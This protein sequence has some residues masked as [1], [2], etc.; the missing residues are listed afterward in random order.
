MDNLKEVD[1]VVQLNEAA[2]SQYTPGM[3]LFSLLVFKKN[4]RVLEQS[5]LIEYLQRNAQNQITI[6]SD[7]KPYQLDRWLSI[8]QRQTFFSQLESEHSLRENT[9]CLQAADPD[10]A[11]PVTSIV[12]VYESAIRD[13]TIDVPGK[14][15]AF[16]TDGLAEYHFELIETQARQNI[17]IINANRV[18]YNHFRPSERW[19]WLQ[20]KNAE[21]SAKAANAHIKRTAKRL[22]KWAGR[23]GTVLQ[24]VDYGYDAWE[25]WEDKSKIDLVLDATRIPIDWIYSETETALISAGII[26]AAGAI[27]VTLTPAG[28]ITLTFGGNYLL[29]KVK[30]FAW[31]AN[32]RQISE[33]FSSHES[34]DVA[35]KIHHSV[36]QVYGGELL[37]VFDI[38]RLRQ[39]DSFYHHTFLPAVCEADSNILNLDVDSAHA[40]MSDLNNSK[41]QEHVLETF[42]LPLQ[43][44]VTTE[45]ENS[46]SANIVLNK[47]YLISFQSGK[48][49]LVPT[50]RPTSI[51]F[52]LNLFDKPATAGSNDV[53]CFYQTDSGMHYGEPTHQA[54]VRVKASLL[55][56]TG[57]GVALAP[58]VGVSIAFDLTPGLLLT[59]G[60]VGAGVG[61]L[62]LGTAFAIK[63]IRE[64][65]EWKNLSP[66]QKTE[67]ILQKQVEHL[68]A[69]NLHIY[70]SYFNPAN[71]GCS[72]AEL[73][74]EAYFGMKRALRNCIAS[75]PDN[76]S[77]VARCRAMEYA[78][79]SGNTLAQAEWE[80][81]QF[82][83]TKQHYDANFIALTQSFEDFRRGN[84]LLECNK[85]L[86]ALTYYYPNEAFAYYAKS[87][88]QEKGNPELAIINMK[89]AISVARSARNKSQQFIDELE[90]ACLQQLVRL[91]IDPVFAASRDHYIEEIK[92]AAF[93]YVNNNSSQQK[94]LGQLFYL[95]RTVEGLKN[96]KQFSAQALQKID[97]YLA[98]HKSDFEANLWSGWLHLDE[99]NIEI[100]KQRVKAVCGREKKSDLSDL[101][102]RAHYLGVQV[103]KAEEDMS[104]VIGHYAEI[105]A[106]LDRNEFPELQLPIAQMHHE[107][108]LAYFSRAE[109]LVNKNQGNINDQSRECY[110][111][112]KEHLSKVGNVDKDLT[113]CMINDLVDVVL[114]ESQINNVEKIRL[115]VAFDKFC[116]FYKEQR[117]EKLDTNILQIGVKTA[118]FIAKVE[119]G[120]KGLN[121]LKRLD[122]FAIEDALLL[123]NINLS[124]ALILNNIFQGLNKQYLQTKDLTLLEQARFYAAECINI[125]EKIQASDW[126]S[127]K[128]LQGYAYWVLGEKSQA[129]TCFST[130]VDS[131]NATAENI[132]PVVHDE[133]WKQKLKQAHTALSDIALAE[134]EPDLAT[135]VREREAALEFDP[136]A[137]EIKKTLGD[138][139]AQ[140]K[141]YEQAHARYQEYLDEDP[142]NVE[143]TMHKVQIYCHQNNL[144][145]ARELLEKTH[146]AR[147]SQQEILEKVPEDELAMNETL[148]KAKNGIDKFERNIVAHDL[149]LLT[150]YIGKL[151]LTHHYGNQWDAKKWHYFIGAY[152]LLATLG[153]PRYM[154]L[155]YEALNDAIGIS[156]SQ[157]LAMKSLAKT[158]WSALSL[159]TRSANIVFSTLHRTG[160][161][162]RNGQFK[163]AID[164]IEV[165]GDAVQTGGDFS[166][167]Y[168]FDDWGALL[169][170]GIRILTHRIETFIHSRKINGQR[171]FEHPAVYVAADFAKRFGQV[172]TGV[173]MLSAIT[174]GWILT[175]GAAL[176]ASVGVGGGVAIV[177]VAAAAGMGML[178]YFAP[179]WCKEKYNN[180]VQHYQNISIEAIIWNGNLSFFQA[181]ELRRAAFK[182]QKKQM[183][184]DAEKLMLQAKIKTEETKSQ[185]LKVLNLQPN[186]REAKA[187]LDQLELSQKFEQG[188]YEWVAQKCILVIKDQSID[189]QGQEQNYL[190]L[191]Q[192]CIALEMP[193]LAEKLLHTKLPQNISANLQLAFLAQRQGDFAAAMQ[194]CKSAIHKIT[195]EVRRA[196]ADIEV[197]KEKM[198]SLGGGVDKLYE[199]KKNNHDTAALIFGVNDEKFQYHRQHDAAVSRQKSYEKQLKRANKQLIA[200]EAA[201][202]QAW[203]GFAGDVTASFVALGMRALVEVSLSISQPYEADVVVIET[204]KVTLTHPAKDGA[205]NSR[206]HYLQRKNEFS[207]MSQKD[208][209]MESRG[210]YLKKRVTSS[211]TGYVQKHTLWAKQQCSQHATMAS[212]QKYLHNKNSNSDRVAETAANQSK[213][214]PISEAIIRYR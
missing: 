111:K 47:S 69:V 38:Q 73:R 105:F 8:Y 95:L 122:D 9:F 144:G 156:S 101:N 108:G 194:Y 17:K 117:L 40:E 139:H 54:D 50:E 88:M 131:A 132:D 87:I 129:K 31:N 61:V 128:L 41:L 166:T 112:A 79:D 203:D 145:A 121:A 93:S 81:D 191:A 126:L 35:K 125:C 116:D 94:P 182:L 62:A 115:I 168:S 167:L 75:D 66:K 179:E 46:V 42:N 12:D 104:G 84:K 118:L 142:G 57:A 169:S 97:I 120:L 143:V 180:F 4:N 39:T 77:Y 102:V 173:G 11:C 98:N 29:S 20:Q 206:K 135:A 30:D 22:G 137:I 175:K 16:I 171:C 127:A 49:I 192:C 176:I 43:T 78:I 80:R 64:H 110:Q 72:T 32:K 51:L 205:A 146:R 154:K 209:Q 213:S 159:G 92:S 67:I 199:V 37:K 99:G 163:T 103:A 157:T 150:G 161:I 109:M 136:H 200:I 149:F 68:N 198:W 6:R 183:Y 114:A 147:T 76:A 119:S 178:Y 197:L 44:N 186:H 160:W 130:V 89:N 25:N 100:A 23:A 10:M 133:S 165:A 151:F 21:E 91:S 2:I 34:Q 214:K 134:Y 181:E 196:G 58:T 107:L 201:V 185:Y 162:E 184:A 172:A 53:S 123:K 193:W 141:N 26:A 113:I 148:R 7:I 208:A 177:V 138:I 3:P 124:K 187:G 164:S 56:V 5:E 27:G 13:A 155:Q 60:A 96:D 33:F 71:W 86:Q 74:R 211:V 202:K 63:K 19:R 188:D 15:K 158:T 28:L 212:R 189:A 140:Q 14:V 190:M 1:L 170:L 55:K 70:R 85:I 174:K 195:E 106:N 204:D 18:N 36:M 90:C 153:S 65:K 24:I 210:A 52:N 59:A 152:D 82:E 83:H 45:F 207:Q 48:T